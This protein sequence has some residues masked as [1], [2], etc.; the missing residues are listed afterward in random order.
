MVEPSGH[1]QTPL[2][3]IGEPSGHSSTGQPSSVSAQFGFT[4]GTSQPVW[5]GLP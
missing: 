4:T 2:D 3:G 5:A 1:L